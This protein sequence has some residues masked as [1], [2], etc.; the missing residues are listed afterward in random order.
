ML[1]TIW[2]NLVIPRLNNFQIIIIARQ[3]KN[4]FKI[5]LGVGEVPLQHETIWQFRDHCIKCSMESSMLQ[6]SSEMP[7]SK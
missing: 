7:N 6:D 1:Y 5:Q 2:T 3:D 4:H